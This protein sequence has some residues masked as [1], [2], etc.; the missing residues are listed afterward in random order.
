VTATSRVLAC[1]GRSLHLGMPRVMGVL[2]IT[3]DSFSDGGTLWGGA[4]DLARIRGVA[5]GMLAT[6]AAVLDIG[7]ESTR[8]GAVAV[9]AAEE[10]RRV[11]PVVEALADL[12]IILSIDTR[13]PEVARLAA[14]A[15]AR[16]LNDVGGFRDPAMIEV[17]AA[18]GMAG[19][20]MHMQ[21]EPGTM[22]DAPVY[23]DVVAEVRAFFVDRIAACKAAGIA[24]TRLILDPGFGFGK[25][26]THNVALLRGLERLRVDGLPL[27]V[28][29]SRKRMIG[30]ITGR[31][32]ADRVA[33]SVA[34]ALFAVAR[35]ANLLRVHDVA[36]TVDALRV[37]AALGDGAA[38]QAERTG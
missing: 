6:G 36:D 8:P 35:G 37:I 30:T 26:Y 12:D 2:N 13:K 3:P 9:D 22:Q 23:G 15:G 1:G 31:D 28:G 21:G 17:L 4:P 24:P 27:L 19:C 34:A 5:E 7:G 14:A 11:I 16:L 10:C 33:G 25:T 29:L 20:I 32:P 38:R 18:T